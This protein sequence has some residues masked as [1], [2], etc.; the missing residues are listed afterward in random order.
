MRS[1]LLFFPNLSFRV[2]ALCYVSMFVLLATVKGQG[3]VAVAGPSKLAVEASEV[4]FS[5]LILCPTMDESGSSNASNQGSRPNAAAQPSSGSSTSVNSNALML[6]PTPHRRSLK[7]LR[8]R[9][10]FPARN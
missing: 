1:K 10:R 7:F 8:K 3:N 5:D 6:R 4:C 2:A 9:A